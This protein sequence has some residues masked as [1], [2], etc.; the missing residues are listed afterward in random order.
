MST[1]E[2]KTGQAAGS[3]VHP[4]VDIVEAFDV[5]LAQIVP[6]LNFDD[7]EDVLAR[8]LQ[9]V[10]RAERDVGRLVGP[11]LEHLL[12]TGDPGP[13]LDHDP[14]LGP[15]PMTLQGEARAGLDRQLLDLEMVT[16]IDRPIGA[17]GPKDLCACGVR[18]AAFAL[19]PLD[20]LPDVLGAVQGRDQDRVRG[21]D[22]D[23]VPDPDDRKKLALGAEIGVAGILD[24][25]LALENV[26]AIV[27][28][29]DLPE[30]GPGADIA[31]SDARGHHRGRVG[32][33]HDRVIDRIRRALGE[34]L[35]VQA[36]EVEILGAPLHGGAAGGH[37]PGAVPVELG[38]VAVVALSLLPQETLP[39]A[40]LWDKL[41]HALAYG[42]LAV[43][44]GIG[45][46]GLRSLLMV[47]LGL[48]VLG[49]GLELA[50]SVT[51]DRD[52]SITD[53]VANIVGVAMGSVATVGTNTLFRD[54]WRRGKPSAP[55]GKS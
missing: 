3:I 54:P 41:N 50:Q 39:E 7:P 6:G 49:A 13:A 21:G 37:D 43:S 18:A 42:L 11:E 45:F 35:A 51:P 4:A 47:G 14:M 8:V 23:H 31:P 28:G 19:E 10:A 40:G 25:D 48:A 52:G 2:Q 26:A 27:L 17:P 15:M 22:D 53:A 12:A 34:G 30:R 55:N 38:Q 36:E 46:K 29:A 9:S 16:R 33:L 20:H 44:G 1:A 32:L 5:V 24:H